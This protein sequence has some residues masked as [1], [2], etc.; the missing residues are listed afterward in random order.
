MCLRLIYVADGFARFDKLSTRFFHANRTRI[1]LRRYVRAFG[2]CTDSPTSDIEQHEQQVI[3]GNASA[4]RHRRVLTVRH[5]AQP[6]HGKIILPYPVFTL[7]KKR[8]ALAP[9]GASVVSTISWKQILSEGRKIRVGIGLISATGQT[10]SEDVLAMYD[11]NHNA[12]RQP[13]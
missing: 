11:A 5:K 4:L 13:D 8:T 10:G 12:N 6:E 1:E 2:R 7:W 9:A 3:V